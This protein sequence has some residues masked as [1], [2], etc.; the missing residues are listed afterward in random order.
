YSSFLLLTAAFL[1]FLVS[2]IERDRR[3]TD[4]RYW[5]ILSAGFAYLSLDELASLHEQWNRPFRALLHTSPHAVT[6]IIAGA[7]GVLMVGIYFV[8][9]LWRLPRADAVRFIVAGTIYVGSALGEE[10]VA[11]LLRKGSPEAVQF[12]YPWQYLGLVTLE[13]AGEMIGV[14]FFIYAVCLYLY[15]IHGR[16]EV[17]FSGAV[18]P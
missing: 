10:T 16:I 7:A 2:R 17:D 4:T 9:F 5:T 1:L 6:W 15:S 11:A 12:E 13:E 14:V 8:P 3:G 18:D